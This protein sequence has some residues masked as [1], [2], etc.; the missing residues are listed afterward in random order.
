MRKVAK[1]AGTGNSAVAKLNKW[2]DNHPEVTLVEIKP[3]IFEES[4]DVI[5]AI[6][7]ISETAVENEEE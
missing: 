1:F 7:D 6:V 5:F 4:Y 3:F 2:L